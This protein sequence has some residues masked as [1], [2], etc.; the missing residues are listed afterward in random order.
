[1]IGPRYTS[2]QITLT[3]PQNE[4][5]STS[6][7]I[8][9]TWEATPGE[10][11]DAS[12]RAVAIL[13]YDLYFAKESETYGIP[14]TVAEKKALKTNLE[15]YTTYKWK[16][17][18]KQTDGQQ[19]ESA[20]G[21]FTT[22]YTFLMG[23]TRDDPEGNENEKPVHGVVFTYMYEIGKYEVTFDQYDAYLLA[24]GQATATIEDEGWG[25]GKRPV[26]NV[27]WRDAAYYCN[28][29]SDQ[30]GYAR[31]YDETTWGLLDS[32]GESTE[33]ITQ[34]QGWR[35]PTEAEWEYAAR[36]GAA[37][38]IDGVENNDYMFSGSNTPDEAGWYDV[39]AGGQTHLVGQKQ[40]NE[41]GFYD[42]T[43]NVIEW[44]HDYYSAY[45]SEVQIN[46]IGTSVGSFRIAR[47][48]G[49]DISE[50]NCRVSVRY[51]ARQSFKHTDCGFRIC[52]TVE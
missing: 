43:G 2:P 36:G 17:A 42:F 10:L 1:L 46:P 32:N 23:N 50:E 34:V 29:L 51:Y 35:L 14:Q 20:E 47:G 52:R 33:D 13:S 25:R 6:L 27:C 41:L 16:V 26:I 7:S 40:P 28:W 15:P 4:A 44:C 8:T 21:V 39:N 37:D 12:V 48:G 18:A 19:T 49:W 24:T 22:A 5:T 9:L 31:A 38:I 11:T 3:Y 30:T 45:A